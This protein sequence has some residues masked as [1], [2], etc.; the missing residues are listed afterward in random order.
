MTRR[1]FTLIEL[2]VV[3]AI[4][5]ILAAI[6]FP[7]FA[8]AREKAR[9]TSCLSNVKQIG[10]A[11]LSYAQDYD[12]MTMPGYQ[13]YYGLGSGTSV[14]A[15][16][17]VYLQPYVKNWQLFKCPS[18]SYAVA[19]NLVGPAY[20]LSYGTNYYRGEVTPYDYTL[21]MHQCSLGSVAD[22]AGTFWVQEG[23]AYTH[24]RG[25]TKPHNDGFNAV[26]ADGHAKWYKN[27]DQNIRMWTKA[28][29]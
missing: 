9:Q 28:A 27:D 14:L 2:L 15:W 22:P 23:F 16:F 25:V 19:A 3:I 10:V 26:L 12:E 6:L 18:L 8:K 7:V 5:A 4:I 17:P 20:E 29:D 11:A 1:G 24:V 13:Y 21:G